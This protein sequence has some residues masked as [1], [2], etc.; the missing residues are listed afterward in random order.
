MAWSKA[1]RG[2]RRAVTGN[3]NPLYE[4]LDMARQICDAF[5][6]AHALGVSHRDLKPGNIKIPPEGRVNVLDWGLPRVV[7]GDGELATAAAATAE[8][9]T[10]SIAATGI[11]II[12]GTAGTGVRSRLAE[13]ESTNEPTSGLS[14][15]FYKRC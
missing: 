4:A 15:Q 13:S 9:P 11:G 5:E 14:A 10:M 7:A 1:A 12:L 2:R 8:S 6:A 3:P